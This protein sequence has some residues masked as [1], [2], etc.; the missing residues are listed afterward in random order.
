MRF[1]NLNLLARIALLSTLSMLVGC[2]GQGIVGQGAFSEVTHDLGG[3]SRLEMHETGAV[4]IVPSDR[5][6]LVVRAQANI[7]EALQVRVNGDQ[8]E[9]DTRSGTSISSRTRIEYRVY[10]PT[11]REIDLRGSFT[12]NGEGLSGDSLALQFSGAVDAEL[13]EISVDEMNINTSGSGELALAGRAGDVTVTSSGS[14]AL[15]ASDLSTQTLRLRSSGSAYADVRVAEQL[16]VNSSGSASVR[17]YGQPRVTQS[18][19]GSA[20]VEPAE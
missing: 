14:L 18:A 11:V 17:Y 3:V 10:L 4:T 5:N 16:S 13:A 19:S 8:L 2:A 12:L 6:E 15:R 9:V 1:T 20:S 7:H